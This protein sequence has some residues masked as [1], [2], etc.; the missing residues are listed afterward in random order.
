[1]PA[2]ISNGRLALLSETPKMMFVSNG[3]WDSVLL[4]A[5]AVQQRHLC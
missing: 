3:A 1:M 4:F 2:E 5:D